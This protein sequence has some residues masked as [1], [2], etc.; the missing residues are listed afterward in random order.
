LSRRRASALSRRRCH[1]RSSRT[2]VNS[3]CCK[4]VHK[5]VCHLRV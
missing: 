2:A 4:N 5:H 3:A 1:S